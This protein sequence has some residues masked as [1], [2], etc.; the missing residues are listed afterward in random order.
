MIVVEL[1]GGLGNQMF[2]YAAGRA[3]AL[4][5][6]VGLQV[7]LGWLGSRHAGET[8]RAYALRARKADSVATKAGRSTGLFARLAARLL[9]M[10]SREEVLRQV[11]HG[12]DPRLAEAGPNARLIGYWQSE[13]YFADSAARIRD[14]LRFDG[15]LSVTGARFAERIAASPAASLH[16]RRGDYVSNA[17]ARAF[18]G[19]LPATWFA[20]AA[21]YIAERAPGVD[22]WVFSD[23]PDWCERELRLP[24]TMSVVRGTAGADED[25]ELMTRCTHHVIA[26][27]SFSWWGG[28]LG[29]REGS[30]V[31]A[32]AH[33]FADPTLDTSTIVPDRWTRL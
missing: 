17:Q 15:E 11:G 31:V 20:A 5:H 21:E 12:Y 10:T 7:D 24:G 29:E 14:E 27:S 30:L 19:L 22:F 16:V 8:P 18:H 26:N 32:P 3:L 4:R 25:L 9:E 28:W 6:G 23:D 33:W 2:Q 1:M 13:R